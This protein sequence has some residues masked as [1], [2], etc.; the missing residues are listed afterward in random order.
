MNDEEQEIMARHAARWRPWIEWGQMV[1][2][3]PVL[4]STGS[5]GLGVVEDDDEEELRHSPQ[6]IRWSRQ[7]QAPSK[8]GSNFSA[9]KRRHCALRKG[10]GPITMHEQK[11]RGRVVPSLP[12]RSGSEWSRLRGW[13]HA[14]L[15]LMGVLG[16]SS[17]A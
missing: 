1:I 14:D 15:P 6:T 17:S 7:A 10:R 16:V 4:D 12:V 3:G 9:Q 5:W 2:F 13:S 11:N 8:S